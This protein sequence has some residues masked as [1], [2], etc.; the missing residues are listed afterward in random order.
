MPPSCFEAPARRTARDHASIA[1]RESFFV[2]S[3]APRPTGGSGRRPARSL[4]RSPP[5]PLRRS[6]APPFARS[7][8]LPAHGESL[9]APKARA[10]GVAEDRV[11][12]VLL[13]KQMEK[14]W[15]MLWDPETRKKED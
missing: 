11:L 10:C 15:K 13:T 6:P 2:L 7:A 1:R 14:P 8:R 12:K 3:R 5:P 4:A 9:S